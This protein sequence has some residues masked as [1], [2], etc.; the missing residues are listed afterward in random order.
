MVEQ[1]TKL[2]LIKRNFLFLDHILKKLGNEKRFSKKGDRKENRPKNDSLCISV[3]F[4]ENFGKLL[5]AS[6]FKLVSVHSYF[7]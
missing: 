4:Q 7:Q 6:D 1:C 3:E 5:L 2:N